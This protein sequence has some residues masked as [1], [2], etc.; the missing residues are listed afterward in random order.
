MKTSTYLYLLFKKRTPTSTDSALVLSFSAN[1]QLFHPNN[2]LFSFNVDATD[3][4]V[5]L[6][7]GLEVDMRL[8]KTPPS[9]TLL[10]VRRKRKLAWLQS[11]SKS[12]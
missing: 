7:R 4:G 8:M 12:A 1:T 10:C 6:R 2:K 5:R 11:F 3:H 9:S